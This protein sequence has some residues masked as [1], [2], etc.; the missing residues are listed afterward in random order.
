M[1]V[2][3]SIITQREITVALFGA[4]RVR[5]DWNSRSDYMRMRIHRLVRRRRALCLRRVRRPS[6]MIEERV[7]THEHEGLER[8]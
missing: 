4:D 6:E 3:T 1:G 7:E 8:G 2:M 5:E